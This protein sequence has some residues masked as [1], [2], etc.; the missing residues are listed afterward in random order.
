MSKVT[1]LRP[2]GS[3]E[4]L[5]RTAL[6]HKPESVLIAYRLPSET[7]TIDGFR[8]GSSCDSE[9]EAVWL[10]LRLLTKLIGHLEGGYETFDGE[11][12]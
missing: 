7:G 4:E 11:S 10:L 5:L 2:G 8:W 3:P 6:G 12:A 1:P 9:G